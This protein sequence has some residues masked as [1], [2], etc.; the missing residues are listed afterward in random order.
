M[1]E[2]IATFYTYFIDKRF[3]RSYI[4]FKGPG[5]FQENILHTIKPPQTA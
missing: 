5:V 2:K 3:Q 1:T 4:A